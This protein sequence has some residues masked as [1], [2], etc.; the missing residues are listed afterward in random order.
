MFTV[1]QFLCF[2]FPFCLCFLFIVLSLS[3]GSCCF[4]VKLFLLL[5]LLKF[6]CG[7]LKLAALFEEHMGPRL[8]LAW[9]LTFWAG[10]QI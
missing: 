8:G 6:L 2:Y 4:T 5:S 1:V 9:P 3:S 7:N 10:L